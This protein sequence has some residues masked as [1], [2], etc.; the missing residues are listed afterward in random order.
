MEG[1][2]QSCF[3]TAFERFMGK[4]VGPNY[5]KGF[6]TKDRKIKAPVGRGKDNELKL[7]VFE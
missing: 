6:S 7:L 3:N 5:G 2:E 4:G 1:S